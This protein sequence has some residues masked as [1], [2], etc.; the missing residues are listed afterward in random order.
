M[1]DNR[2]Q[3]PH[4]YLHESDDLERRRRK[5]RDREMMARQSRQAQEQ[6]LQIDVIERREREVEED[7]RR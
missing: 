3:R 6:G 1:S 4:R 2:N 7:E 5:L